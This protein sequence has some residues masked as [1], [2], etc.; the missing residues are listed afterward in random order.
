MTDYNWELRRWLRESTAR[1]LA[2]G[3][4]DWHYHVYVER[5]YAS[6]VWC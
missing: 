3:R 4:T 6:L 5:V 1:L 2:E